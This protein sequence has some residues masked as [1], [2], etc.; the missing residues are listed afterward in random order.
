MCVCSVKCVVVECVIVVTFW[1]A[2]RWTWQAAWREVRGI[3]CS[4][5]AFIVFSPPLQDCWAIYTGIVMSRYAEHSL[6]SDVTNAKL[7]IIPN[8]DVLMTSRCDDD[9]N[10]DITEHRVAR[11]LFVC[12]CVRVCACT[13]CLPDLAVPRHI[14]SLV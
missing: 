13:C 12:A 14:L 8:G 10:A 4:R 7:T 11:K 2:D 6:Q 9:M 3:G 5:C 1:Q